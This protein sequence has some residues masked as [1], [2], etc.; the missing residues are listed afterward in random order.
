M[1][2]AVGVTVFTV[3]VVAG[4]VS[5]SLSWTG[6]LSPAGH[7]PLSIRRVLAA[8]LAPLAVAVAGV[9]QPGRRHLQGGG[10]GP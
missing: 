2:P 1:V 7:M 10:P 3:A 6:R 4:Q 5:G 9:D 8:G